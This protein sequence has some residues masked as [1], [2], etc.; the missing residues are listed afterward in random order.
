MAGMNLE[1]NFRYDQGSD[2]MDLAYIDLIANRGTSVLHKSSVVSKLLLTLSFIISIILA[3][4]VLHL[5]VILAIII[6][7][8]RVAEISFLKIGHFALYP[9][10]FSLV[11]AIFKFTVSYTAGMEVVLRAVTA[12]LTLILLILT[13]PYYQIFSILNRLLPSILVDGLFFTYRIFFIL[14]KEIDNLLTNLKLKGGY[15]PYRILFNLKNLAGSLGVL[16]IHSFDLSERMYQVLTIRGYT[17]HIQL[18]QDVSFVMRDYLLL[19]SGVSV[20]LM[21]VI[22]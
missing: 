15:H 11:F 14:L 7:G 21:V 17:G 6:S 16:F 10:F 22:L 13:T 9:A 19:L 18:E 4:N 20:I 12:A 3:Q 8:Y 1:R 5:L 2:M